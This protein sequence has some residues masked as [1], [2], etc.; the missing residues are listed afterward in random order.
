MCRPAAERRSGLFKRLL[1]YGWLVAVPCL[2]PAACSQ[3]E[4]Q[5][6]A[7]CT[8]NGTTRSLRPGTGSTQSLPTDLG[9]QNIALEQR[10]AEMIALDYM[11]EKFSVE[12]VGLEIV[13]STHDEKDWIV[14]I[15][16]EGQDYVH[17]GISSIYIPK[18]L[19]IRLVGGM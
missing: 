11:N 7:G 8:L 14:L 19:S 16:V 1:P 17:G 4:E 2:G 12:G 3:D 15:A 9:R 18:Q 6:T 5:I 13:D 10:F